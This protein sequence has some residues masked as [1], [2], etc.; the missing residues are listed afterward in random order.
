MEDGW[1][2]KHKRQDGQGVYTGDV[3]VDV[4]VGGRDAIGVDVD[5][6]PAA[7]ETCAGDANAV[8]DVAGPVGAVDIEY[9]FRGI[10]GV[11]V[12]G[13]IGTVGTLY[14]G[15]DAH[16]EAPVVRGVEVEVEI[17]VGCKGTIRDIQ[18]LEV[19]MVDIRLAAEAELSTPGRRPTA[20]ALRNPRRAYVCIA[21]RVPA[22]VSHRRNSYAMTT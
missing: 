14:T 8:V 18:T 9:A 3:D 13:V 7:V 4:D 6:E 1:R 22:P 5:V 15:V 10:T 17:T 16:T 21:Q 2:K 20:L 11:T 19:I 12:I